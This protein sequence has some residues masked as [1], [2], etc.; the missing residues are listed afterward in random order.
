MSVAKM[1]DLTGRVAVITGA[2]KGLGN[3]MAAAL[4]AAGA[5]VAIADI[6]EESAGSVA[7]RFRDEGMEALAV[8]VDVSD[9][10]QVEHMTRAIGKEYGRIDVLV[11]NAGIGHNAPAEDMEKGDWDRVISVNLTGV[12][13]CAQSVGRVMISQGQG[14]IINISSM[15][16]LVANYP[17]PQIAYNASKAGVNMITKSLASEWAQYGIRVNAIAPGYMKTE[18]TR[19]FFEDPETRAKWNTQVNWIQPTPMGR[20]GEPPELAGTVVYLSSEA[21]SFVTGH[22]L[23]VDGG[24]TAR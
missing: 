10:S 7:Q 6:D 19:P 2:A 5:A 16:G 3:A 9:Q 1:F 8:Q 22:V 14:S 21:S 24:Y 15:S 20:A 11:R 4:A 12:F 18:L 23:V 13:L 17:Q